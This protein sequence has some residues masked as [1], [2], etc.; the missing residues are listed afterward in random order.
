MIKCASLF[1]QILNEISSSKFAA[2]TAK[3]G[4]DKNAKGFS[5]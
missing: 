4:N 3:M 5:S 2:L 1:R